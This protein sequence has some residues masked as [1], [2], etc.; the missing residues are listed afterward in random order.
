MALDSSDQL[1]DAFHQTG[2]AANLAP[3]LGYLA[4]LLN[5]L[6]RVVEATTTTTII[7]AATAIPQPAWSPSCPRSPNSSE[8]VWWPTFR[9]ALVEGRALDTGQSVAYAHDFTQ[10]SRQDLTSHG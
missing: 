4:V 3:T 8:T 10:R 2:D 7:G 9:R 1:I 5:R 6:G